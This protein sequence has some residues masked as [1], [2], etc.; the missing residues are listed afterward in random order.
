LAAA[1]QLENRGEHEVSG[2]V[3]LEHS[4][5][6]TISE[7]TCCRGPRIQILH[8]PP[9][10]ARVSCTLGLMIVTGHFLFLDVHLMLIYCYYSF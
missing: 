8:Q 7:C 1:I 3:S 4:Q 10:C 2:R 9:G 6:N 5:G